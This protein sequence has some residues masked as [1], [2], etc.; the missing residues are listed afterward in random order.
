MTKRTFLR[1]GGIGFALAAF[2]SVLVVSSSRADD[3]EQEKDNHAAVLKVLSIE[4]V[5]TGFQFVEGPVWHHGGNAAQSPPSL[6]GDFLFF[7]DIP[8]NI[9]Y[10]WSQASGVQLFRADSSATNGNTLDLQ[11][12][13]ISCE[14]FPR[15]RVVRTNLDGTVTV[16]AD[17]YEGKRLNAPNDVVVKSDGTI[18]FTDPPYSTPTE[19]LELGFFGVYQFN[20]ET[21]VLKVVVEDFVRP[22]GLALSPDETK[23]YVND[24]CSPGDTTPNGEKECVASGSQGLLKVYKIERS[25]SLNE[26]EVFAHAVDPTKAGVPDGMKVDTQGNVYTT[27]P[28][29]IWVFNRRGR[30]LGRIDIPEVPA[31]CGWGRQLAHALGTDRGRPDALCDRTNQPIPSSAKNPRLR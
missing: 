2:T 13:L 14:G 18:Y 20:P 15:R 31:N 8:A 24:S 21:G 23:L 7:S 12:R 1:M 25:G 30:L 17:H 29:G 11:G 4:K 22:N 28:G 3:Q 10:K 5:A 6:V 26:G 16:L 9:I 27:G 19:E